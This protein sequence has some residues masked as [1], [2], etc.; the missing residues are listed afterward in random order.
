MPTLHFDYSCPLLICPSFDLSAHAGTQSR[1]PGQ[2]PERCG[3]DGR[4]ANHMPQQTSSLGHL[5]DAGQQHKLRECL[6]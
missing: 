3:L 6:Q 5:S 2:D 4:V 1:V